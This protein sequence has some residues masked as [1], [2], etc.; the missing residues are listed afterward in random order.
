M[1][2]DEQLVLTGEIDDVGNPKR[3]NSG[4]SSRIG[5]EIENSI[6]LSELFSV[7]TNITL[8]S[9]KNKNIFSMV[10]GAL[11]NYGK[12]NISFSP[13]FIGSNSINYRYSE[14]LNFTFLSKYV[15]KQYMSNTDQ[16]NSI[17]DSYFVNDL[18]ISYLLQPNKIFESISI[19][20][21]INN[22]LNKEY[23]SNGYYYTYDDTWSIPGQ[24][25]TLDGAGYYPQATRNFLAG[26]IFKF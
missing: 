16:P 22:L 23:I 14:N 3:T 10:D 20:L 1:L 9:N 24:I 6:K 13:S 26:F 12:T 25:T 5:L 11:Y 15:G 7:Q 21:L 17:L 2:Y 8:S 4:S 18:S 19:N